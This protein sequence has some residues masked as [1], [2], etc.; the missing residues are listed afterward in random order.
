MKVAELKDEDQTPIA[1]Q[2]S[3]AK[4]VLSIGGWSFGTNTFSDMAKDPAAR[5]LFI[6]SSLKLAADHG[7]VGIDLDWE[8]PGTTAAIDKGQG[9]D[10]AGN[11]KYGGRTFTKA[12]AAL[13][14]PNFCT[15]LTEYRTAINAKAQGVGTD[16]SLS[17]AASANPSIVPSGYDFQCMNKV[18]D[19]V[20]IMSYDLH[21]SWDAFAGGS[22]TQVDN[23]PDCCAAK[24]PCC[25][26]AKNFYGEGNDGYW[27]SS[28]YFDDNI[29]IEYAAKMWENGGMPK[30]KL[31]VGLATYGR[32]QKLTT[33]QTSLGDPTKGAGW[34]G[35][36]TL[37]G[38]FLSYFEILGGF[39]KNTWHFNEAGQFLWAS[40]CKET[41]VSFEDECTLTY[42]ADWV[43]KNGYHGVMIW[44]ISSDQSLNK[45]FPLLNAIS[46]A[47]Q[48][49]PMDVKSCPRDGGTLTPDFTK[50]AP[51]VCAGTT[52]AP[53]KAGTTKAPTKAG[54]PSSS[55]ATSNAGANSPSA[56]GGGSNGGGSGNGGGGANGGGANGSGA[57]GGGANG[58]GGSCGCSGGGCSGGPRTVTTTTTT[59]TTTY[60]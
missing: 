19:W 55:P 21:G 46:L 45:E 39:P 60:H 18:L 51:S 52:K 49:K 48:G 1:A 28:G 36:Y 16:F 59:T 14:K 11:P 44:E 47:M 7:F 54:T 53:T 6:D 50:V 25:V 37:E 27:G 4:M 3:D 30:N 17:I 9:L 12:Q 15:L 41:Y 33:D 10:P 13:D 42:K 24:L 29:S 5:K 8:Y 58:G 34:E 2:G 38:G 26:S 23:V 22:T 35:A 40:D 20:G 57:N 32:T 43:A 31:V 56:N